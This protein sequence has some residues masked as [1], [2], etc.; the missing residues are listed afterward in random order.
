V[1]DALPAEFGFREDVTFYTEHG[2]LFGWGCVLAAA[3]LAGWAGR[4]MLRQ[5]IGIW[6]DRTDLGDSTAFVRS[7]RDDDRLERLR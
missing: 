5:T 4:Q 1:V 7:L 6:K 2:D 3:V